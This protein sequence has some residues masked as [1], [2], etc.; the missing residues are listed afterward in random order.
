MLR[1]LASPTSLGLSLLLLLPAD[2]AAAQ[3]VEITEAQIDGVLAACADPA[4]EAC[5]AA[6]AALAAAFPGVPASVV[7]GTLAAELAAQSNAALAAGGLAGPSPFAAALAGLSA[8]ATSL[9]LGDLGATI[10]TIATAVQ[11][12]ETVDVGA[13]ASGDVDGAPDGAPDVAASPA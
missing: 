13:I 11:S 12:G 10:A 9:G 6:L 5:A 2:F 1:S 4:G 8:F 3:G 7:V